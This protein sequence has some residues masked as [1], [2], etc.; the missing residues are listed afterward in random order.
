MAVVVGASAPHRA[1][2]FDACRRAIEQLKLRVP[3]W[4]KEWAPD[5][6]ANWVNLDD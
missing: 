6:S 3:I 5:G 2:A 4:K 1:E